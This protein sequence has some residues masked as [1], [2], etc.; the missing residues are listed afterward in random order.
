MINIWFCLLGILL[1]GELSLGASWFKTFGGNEQDTATSIQETP[2]G[3]YI[4]VGYTESLGAGDYDAFVIKLDGEGNVL[5]ERTL[6]GPGR[7]E[8]NSVVQTSDEGYVIVG[9]TRSSGA[10]GNDI[11]V[12][13]LDGDGN[14]QWQKTLG[15]SGRDEAYSIRETSDG[16]YILAGFMESSGRGYDLLVVKLEKNGSVQWYKTLGGTGDD[17]AF[18]LQQTSDGGYIVAGV[19]ES[20]GA[21]RSDAWVIKLD[22]DGRVQWQKIFGGFDNDWFFS[23]RQTSEGSYVAV[24][25]TE[26]FGA[27][28]SDAWI[29]KLDK[30]GKTQWLKTLGGS[31]QDRFKSV[32]ETEDGYIAVGGTKSFGAGESDVWIVK[33]SKNGSV[34]WQRTFGGP[35]KEEANAVVKASD[36][37][38]VIAG[39]TESFGSG[40]YDAWAMKLDRYG[41]IQGCAEQG[42]SNATPKEV[43]PS[44]ASISADFGSPTIKVMGSGARAT[45][46]TFPSSR[47]CY[48]SPPL[49]GATLHIYINGS[50]R[51]LSEPSGIDCPSLCSAHFS[52]NSSVTLTAISSSGSNSVSWEG[53]CKSCG[54]SNTCTLYMTS[55]VSCTVVF[56]TSGNTNTRGG[57]GC[58]TGGVGLIYGL[59][60]IVLVFLFG[61]ALSIGTWRA[62]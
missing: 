41:N 47:I 10:G 60:P 14:I 35:N 39:R 40:E 37:A 54:S 2:E 55:D 62:Y 59:F 31:G 23:I 57:G 53:D 32:Y 36:G 26:S 42:T 56:G 27:G 13:K 43:N 8:A 46:V 58:S 3:S 16:D 30:D 45:E 6:G 38:Y 33:L 25:V 24:G 15:D 19:T 21:G 44:V 18:S 34:Q 48:Y 51:V 20:F 5:W 9:S 17:W 7:E 1:I 50:G 4:L 28:R 52:Q 29:V 12:V 49:R 61:R 22:G 11:W